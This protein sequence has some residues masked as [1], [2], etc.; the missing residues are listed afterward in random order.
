MRR[1]L[2]KTFNGYSVVYDSNSKVNPF[3]ILDRGKVET[4]YGDF[5]SCLIHIGRKIPNFDRIKLE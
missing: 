1:Q 4:R 5:H 3:I 2:V